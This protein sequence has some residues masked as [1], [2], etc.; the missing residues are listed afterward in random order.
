[1]SE[2]L[3]LDAGGLR[4]TCHVA[5][6]G[7]LVLLL[8]GFPDGPES[9]APQI[10]ALAAAGYRAAAVTL[11]GYEVSSRPADGDYHLAALAQDFPRWMDALGAAR[12]HL[13]GHDWG[14]TIAFAAA[15]TA[16]ARVASLSMLAVPHPQRFLAVMRKDRAQFRRSTY[17]LFF[18]LRGIADWWVRRDRAACVAR[19]WR[20]WSPGWRP[21]AGLLEAARARFTDAATCGAALTY[22]RHALDQRTQAGKATQALL[23]RPCAVP[24]LGLAGV[25]DGCI[26]VDAFRAAMQAEDF[27]AG[28]RVETIADAGHFLHAEQPDV[29]NAALLR[30]LA[31]CAQA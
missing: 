24:T 3:F 7:P 12:A 27:S 8:H 1:M 5:G 13:V 15:V 30:H 19:L 22:Y 18:Q 14:A 17:I 28:L 11:R 6:Q 26:G 16:P 20:R 29:V 4:F 10:A 31:A 2:T 21:P 25:N 23:A 9:F